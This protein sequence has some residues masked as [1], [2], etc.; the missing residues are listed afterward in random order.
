[1]CLHHEFFFL[2]KTLGLGALPHLFDVFLNV[3]HHLV[4]GL[5]NDTDFIGRID[6][7]GIDF[8]ITLRN[9]VRHACQ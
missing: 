7:D 6:R 4:K 8:K 9:L 1:M 3:D 2:K 5:G